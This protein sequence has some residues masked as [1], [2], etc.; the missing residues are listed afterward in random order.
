M[1][2]FSYEA[3]TS[4]GSVEQGAAVAS[5]EAELA[6]NLS[7]RQMSL[8][9]V[10][11]DAALKARGRIRLKELAELTRYVSITC[12][13]GLSII[14]GLE[15]YARQAPTPVMRRILGEMV[16]DVRGGM[17]LGDAMTRH[18]KSF[19]E[20]MLALTRAAESSGSMDEVMSRLS[21]QIEF[22]L[23]VR[24]KVRGALV[25][26]AILMTAVLGLVIL[27]ITFLLPRLMGALLAFNV[28]LPAPTRALL[29]TSN[30]VL[31]W[32]WALLS[33]AV[34]FGCLFRWFAG[35]PGG[36]LFLDRLLRRLPAAGTLSKLGSESRFIA[37]LRTL[38]SS[39]VEAVS[40][41]NFSAQSCGSA[42]MQVRLA[43]A[44]RELLDG[45]T[46]SQALGRTGLLRPLVMR[47]VEL[48]ER[49]GRMDESLEF[50]VAWFETEIPR[51]VQ[52]CT[53]LLEPIILVFAAAT[54]SFVLLA[55]LMPVFSMYGAV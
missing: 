9:K 30:F 7:L 11:R 29:A 6:K 53:Q 34:A 46:F 44:G 20:E 52:R 38:L 26:P 35:T 5:D 25:Y 12:K 36:A 45:D 14:D 2:I 18:G 23:E 50:C 51:A 54:V 43:Q 8:L 22:Q 21:K 28:E 32:W 16:E 42:A 49:S 17:T 40:A 55:A 47:M 15:D 1:P 27:L 19:P 31:G 24:S 37:T 4:A 39:G 13:A 33:G 3:L 10:S 41:L 48:G